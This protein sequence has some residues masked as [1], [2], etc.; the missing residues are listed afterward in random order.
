MAWTV[1]L[2]SEVAKWFEGLDPRT[3]EGVAAALDLL[4]ERGPA[5]GRPLVDTLQGS[6]LAH[7]KE[8]RPGS[9]G[10][11]EVR[12]LFAFDPER[13]AIL[14]TAGDKAGRW[15]QW[16][17][18]HIPLAEERYRRWLAGDYAEEDRV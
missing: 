7:L 10:G 6:A 4:E 1:I 15:K 12:I 8:L 5:L 14:L 3:A 16:Y 2:L 18:D 13:Q 9:A 11:S 17:H